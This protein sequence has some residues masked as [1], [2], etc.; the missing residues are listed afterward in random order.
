MPKSVGRRRLQTNPEVSDYSP[1]VSLQH[2]GGDIGLR[3]QGEREGVCVFD[4]YLC[5]FRLSWR[6]KL[7]P[8]TSQEKL[9]SG[10]LCVRSWIIRL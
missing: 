2:S 4:T 5:C 3:G 7:L 1:H 9:S 10:L 8:H 6:L